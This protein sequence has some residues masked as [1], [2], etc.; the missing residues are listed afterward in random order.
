MEEPKKNLNVAESLE[1]SDEVAVLT[2]GAS[3]RPMLREHRDLTIIK[4]LNCKPRRGDVLLYRKQGF[5]FLVLHRVIRVKKQGYIIRGD[6]NY[7]TEYD[8][9]DSDIVGIL[10]E[11][12]RDGKYFN[13]KNS[14]RYHIYVFWILNSYFIRYFY[15]KAVRPI[16]LFLKKG[17]DKLK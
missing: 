5:D 17:I 7:Y 1:I 15:I 14:L 10:E 2:R 13:C 4:R 12:Y 16:L 3:M 9:K 8:V 11:F 6:N